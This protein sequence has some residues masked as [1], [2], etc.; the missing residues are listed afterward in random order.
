M[1]D[2]I[3]RMKKQGNI[4]ANI[5]ADDRKIE[6]LLVGLRKG[7]LMA[8]VPLSIMQMTDLIKA[9]GL[10]G[11]EPVTALREIVTS[12]KV[13][14]EIAKVSGHIRH[15][16]IDDPVYAEESFITDKL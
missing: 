7:I 5:S 15:R 10:T 1:S 14:D 6:K 2:Y 12:K 4:H 11:E 3:D 8:K 9:Y 13:R 16:E